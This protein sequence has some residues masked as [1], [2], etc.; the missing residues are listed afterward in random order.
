MDDLDGSGTTDYVAGRILQ[1]MSD[2]FFVPLSEE[3]LA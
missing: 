1:M 2:A 3:M